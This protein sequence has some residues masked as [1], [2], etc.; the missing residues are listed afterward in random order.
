MMC[1]DTLTSCKEAWAHSLGE[2]WQN[3]FQASDTDRPSPETTPASQEP[4]FTVD[5][6]VTRVQNMRRRK[7]YLCFG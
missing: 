1:G 2:Y 6:I 4:V 5:N 7:T 3:L